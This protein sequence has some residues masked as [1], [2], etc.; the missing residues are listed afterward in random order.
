MELNYCDAKDEWVKISVS[1]KNASSLED[2]ALQNIPGR[3]YCS[4]D[5]GFCWKRDCPIQKINNP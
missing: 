1:N 5:D 3:I 4:G 2:Y